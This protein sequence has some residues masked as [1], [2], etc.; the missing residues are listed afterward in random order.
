MGVIKQI[1]EGQQLNCGQR[2][3][4]RTNESKPP[5]QNNPRGSLRGELTNPN[6]SNDDPGEQDYFWSARK[7]L[8]RTDEHRFNQIRSATIPSF[9]H[10]KQ[11]PWKPAKSRNVIWQ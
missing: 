2:A 3:N 7:H 5:E 8:C 4:K 10:V 11:N 1:K 9:L 6:R